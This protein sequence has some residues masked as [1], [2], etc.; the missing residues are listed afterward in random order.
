MKNL[1]YAVI[2][3]GGKQYIVSEGEEL[4]VDKLTK[5][6]SAT[7]VLLKSF[8]GKV[9]IGKPVITGTKIDL[10][11]VKDVEKGEKIR[12][13]KY[14]AKSRYRKTIGFRPAFTRLR[15]EKIH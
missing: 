9:E 10:K 4:I 3:L 12:V 14:K 13:F 2:K 6:N 5:H 1:N 8:D 7:Q 11:V 15:V